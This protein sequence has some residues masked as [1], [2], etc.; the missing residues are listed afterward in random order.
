MRK[1]NK[2]QQYYDNKEIKICQTQI[3]KEIKDYEKL[4]LQENHN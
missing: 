3:K 4:L 1:L 2:Q